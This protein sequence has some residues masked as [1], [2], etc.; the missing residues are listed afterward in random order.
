MEKTWKWNRFVIFGNGSKFFIT[1]KKSF[2]NFHGAAPWI[3]YLIVKEEPFDYIIEF[4]SRE[5]FKIRNEFMN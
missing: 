3:P 4:L 2:Y 5:I 1:E